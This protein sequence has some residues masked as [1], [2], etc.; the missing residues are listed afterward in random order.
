MSSQSSDTNERSKSFFCH[1][2][3][4]SF[5]KHPEAVSEIMRTYKIKK[6][7]LS[8][9]FLIFIEIRNFYVQHVS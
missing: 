7:Q 8:N 5:L 6:I 2:C 3:S 1:S 9:I 4:N